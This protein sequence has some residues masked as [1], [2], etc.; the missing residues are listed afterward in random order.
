[1]AAKLCRVSEQQNHKTP[2]AEHL[3]LWGQQ[4]GGNTRPPHLAVPHASLPAFLHELL[5]ALTK[6]AASHTK[7]R[8]TKPQTATVVTASSMVPALRCPAR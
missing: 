1:M 6:L 2:I 8:V 3:A 5:E 4:E 7:P